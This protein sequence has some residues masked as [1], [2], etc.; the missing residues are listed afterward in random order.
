M[1]SFC[2]VWFRFR[3]F[4]RYLSFRLEEVPR[5][6]RLLETVQ[7]GCPGHGRVRALMASAGRVGCRWD[8]SMPGWERQ[9]LPGLSN[10][11]GPIQHFRSAT[12]SAWRDK[13]AADLC[14]GSGFRFGPLLDVRGSHQLLASPHVRDR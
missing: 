7:E 5:V 8:H 9:G 2:L 6:Y 13:I 10:F 11:A 14:V 4:C 3:L 12:L 1:T